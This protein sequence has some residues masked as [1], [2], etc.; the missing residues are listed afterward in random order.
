MSA[1]IQ[2][3]RGR[4][5]RL[6]AAEGKW[7]KRLRQRLQNPAGMTA[8]A[9]LVGCGRSGTSMLLHH[10]GRSPAV[11]AYNENDAEAFER[12]RLRPAPAIEGII[13]RSH[14]QL[15]LFKPILNTH[16]SREFLAA[17]PG[18]KLIF[19]YRHFEDV[20]NS[21]LKRF[22]AEN[23]L[24]HVNTWVS[25]NF[26]E[27]AAAPPPEATKAAVRELWR[28]SLSLESAAG[29]YWLFYNRLYFDLGLD[30][31]ERVRLVGYERL[32]ANP[33]AE[34]AAVCAFLGTAYLPLMAEGV[35]A[36]SIGRDS[37]PALAADIRAA[38][39]ALWRRLEASRPGPEAGAQ[40]NTSETNL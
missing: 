4:W 14:A 27:F 12:Y 37:A 8:P 17:Y 9:F 11:T 28:P 6:Q 13:G 38:C 10:L 3:L 20:V 39:E 5:R 29:L 1:S 19:V 25:D 31:E 24:G 26:G 35:F 34:L 32:A 7:R 36:S 15:T 2:G 33:A 18:S 30:R 16:Q 23:R 22:G 40:L 21:S